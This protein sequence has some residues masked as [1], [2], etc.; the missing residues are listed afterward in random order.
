MSNSMLAEPSHWVKR[1]ASLSPAGE[2]LDLACGGGRN[3]RFLLAEGFTVTCLDRDDSSFAD[4]ASRGAKTILHDLE[5]DPEEC[6]WPFPSACF[7]AI[8]VCNYLHRPLFPHLLDSLQQGGLLIY[9]TFATGNEQFGKPSSP[10]FLL[11]PG[12]LLRQIHTAPKSLMHVIGYEEGFIVEPKP[13]IV[14]RICARKAAG[15]APEDKLPV[16]L[17]EDQI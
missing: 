15:S 4:L 2:V 16:W 11:Q 5:P 14:Q 12:E 13:A 8:V 7:A 1:F 10:R 3:S 9:E 17:N 6:N